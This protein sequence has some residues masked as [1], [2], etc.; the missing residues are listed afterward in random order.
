[1]VAPS[2]VPQI[3]QCSLDEALYV[4]D[5]IESAERRT[6]GFGLSMLVVRTVAGPGG[7]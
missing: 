5:G 4:L 6:L 7:G 2:R 3:A 1:M